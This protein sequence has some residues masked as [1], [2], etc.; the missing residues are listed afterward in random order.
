[1]LSRTLA[2]ANQIHQ[3]KHSDICRSV[4]R[5]FGEQRV[6]PEADR[7]LEFRQ[8][9]TKKA[10]KGGLTAEIDLIDG[11]KLQCQAKR[12]NLHCLEC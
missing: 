11:L 12:G 3:P 6:L 2:E 10:E 9:E 7:V 5:I 8:M 4:S 1:M